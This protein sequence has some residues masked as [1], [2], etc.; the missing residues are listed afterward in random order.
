MTFEDV[1]QGY[2]PLVVFRLYVAFWV[3]NVFPEVHL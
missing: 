3:L 2:W 1:R